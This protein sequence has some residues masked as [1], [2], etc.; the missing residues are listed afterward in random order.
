M[1]D[2]LS[3]A[4][5]DLP[6]RMLTLLRHEYMEMWTSILNVTNAKENNDSYIEVSLNS[7]SRV[8]QFHVWKWSVMFES[9][10]KIILDNFF[11]QLNLT[12]WNLCEKQ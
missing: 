11:I 9:A 4:V 10:W 1:V 8:C 5:H 12:F 2:N 7:K 6:M 3:I